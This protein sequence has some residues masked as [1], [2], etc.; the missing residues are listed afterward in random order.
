MAGA[1]ALV[2]EVDE[3]RINRRL[4]IGLCDV[5]VKTLDKAIKLIKEHTK[6]GKPVSIGLVSNCAE[7]S[8][9]NIPAVELSRISSP[10]KPRPTMS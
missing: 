2:V 3:A 6:P 10:I 7:V 8:S 5:K 4:A 9:G 1:S